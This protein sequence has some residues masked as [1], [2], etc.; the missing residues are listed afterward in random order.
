[1]LQ[2]PVGPFFSRLAHDLADAGATVHKVN[3]NAGD[4]LFYSSDAINFT[5]PLAEWGA[6]LEKLILQLEVDTILLFGDCREPHAQAKTIAAKHGLD[7]GVF[8]EG[9]LR[10][11]HITLERTGVNG[12]SALP[13]SPLV[14]L[15]HPEAPDVHEREVGNTF[16]HMVWWGF[17]YFTV[18][19]L[20]KPWF[21]HYKHHRRMS[22]LE[23]LPWIRS[24]W[25]HAW[26]RWSERGCM[27]QLHHHKSRPYYL[28]PLQVHNDSQIGM[29]SNY[30]DVPSFIDEVMTSFSHNA[31]NDT[32]LV[33]KHHP[34]DR[35]YTDYTAHIARQ[36]TAL[37]IEERC[38]YLHDQHLPTMLDHARG[39][40]VVNST[41]G[42][43]A[44][45]HGTPT[46]AMGAAIYNMQGLC[47]QGTLDE[48]WV[49][50]PRARP[51]AALL[52][53]FIRHLKNVNQ[54]NG[55][56]YRTMAGGKGKTGLIWPVRDPAIAKPAHTPTAQ[57]ATNPIQATG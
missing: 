45:R 44:L 7:L 17:C 15:N 41:V 12:Y 40:I 13:R 49:E 54:I 23:A 9:Y 30:K 16:W 14:Y 6:F 48:F 27:E 31:P 43:Q 53:R 25:R 32:L 1:M 11:R 35:G 21:R 29:H 42:L 47:F 52:Q 36:A 34:M 20:G 33:I 46:K 26:Y 51:D 24:V 3:F 39:V 18:G 37:G 28:V 57:P 5:R 38:L 4:W 19:A 50:A 8:E 22:V 2:G 56:F 10:P 55:S